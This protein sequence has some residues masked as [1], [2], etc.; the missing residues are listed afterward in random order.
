MKA[1]KE[2][3]CCVMAVWVDSV[4]LALIIKQNVGEGVHIYKAK[5]TPNQNNKTIRHLFQ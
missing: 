2:Q 1:E 5:P 3:S 4:D